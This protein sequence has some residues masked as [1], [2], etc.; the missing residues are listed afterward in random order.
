MIRKFI[1][2]L[3]H[4]WRGF[5]KDIDALLDHTQPHGWVEI[6]LIHANGPNKG[7]V[8]RSQTVPMHVP[9]LGRNVI[10]GFVS[11]IPPY[12]GRDIMRRK[13]V[14][15]DYAGYLAGDAYTIKK[16][17]IGSGSTAET[18]A[19]TSL[20]TPLV[21]NSIKEV[22]SVEFDATYP[23]V[24]FIT[25]WAENEA[26]QSISEAGLWCDAQTHFWA[27]KTFDAF[28]KNNNFTLQI[29]WTIRF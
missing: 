22:T 8:A 17:Q 3:V 9:V 6:R 7:E 29:R 28:T 4:A 5:R 10:T 20:E 11:P 24:T 1:R 21:A 13:I 2:H 14:H 25:S 16:I 26:N 18:S 27:R 19:D 23:Y 15:S 12:S